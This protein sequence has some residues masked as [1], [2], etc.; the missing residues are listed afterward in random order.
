MSSTTTIELKNIGIEDISDVLRKV[1]KSFGFKFGVTELKDVKTFGELCDIITNKVQGENVNDCTTQQAFY[2]VRDAMIDTLLI[3]KNDIAP[4]TDL[5]ILF[6]RQNRIQK[7][8]A[9]KRKLD[10]RFDILEMK[11][12]L[13]WIY[14]A[15]IS[16]SILIFFFKWQYAL[17]GIIFFSLFGWTMNKFFATELKYQTVGQLA[18][19]FARENYLKARR[20]SAT[21]NR[22]EVEQKVKELFADYLILEETALTREAT[23]E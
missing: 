10:L 1:E 23:F 21:V 12:W 11:E 3:D 16:I 6:L 19:K 9:F 8:K 14:F 20:N 7:V 22:K 5:Q 17:S 13:K 4:D 2:K 15:G 18:E